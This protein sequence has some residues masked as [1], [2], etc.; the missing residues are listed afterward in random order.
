LTLVTLLVIVGTDLVDGRLA[1]ALG[2]QRPF[3]AMLD[4]TI[5]WVVILALYSVLSDWRAGLVG[6]VP[7][8]IVKF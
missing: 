4:S 8:I 3:G 5:D 7:I 1:R 2:Q 6:F